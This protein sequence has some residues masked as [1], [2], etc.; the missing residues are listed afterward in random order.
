MPRTAALRTRLSDLVRANRQFRRLLAQ[1]GPLVRQPMDLVCR[2]VL[3]AST[4][5]GASVGERG[6]LV[7]LQGRLVAVLV[8]ID[9]GVEADD[10]PAGWFLEAGFG[11]CAQGNPPPLFS[12]V[13]EAMA[14]LRDDLA[15]PP[16][17]GTADALRA[18]FGRDLSLHQNAERLM[19][20][21]HAASARVNQPPAENKGGSGK[22]PGP[23]KG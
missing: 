3:V 23:L 2:P 9:A 12:T 18:A 11:R 7:F 14:W 5:Y 15:A 16:L 8:H 20:E 1:Y 10:A 19:A 21:V 22:A 13:R 17:A 6:C 4:G